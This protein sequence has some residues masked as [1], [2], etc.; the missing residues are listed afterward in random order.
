M[1][2]PVVVATSGPQPWAPTEP[3]APYTEPQAIPQGRNA[4]ESPVD[5]VHKP[6]MLDVFSGPNMPLSKAFQWC[7]WDTIAFDRKIQSTSAQ[8]FNH[9]LSKAPGQEALTTSSTKAD[10]IAAAFDC[11]TKSRIREIKRVIY[12]ASGK[13]RNLPTPLRSEQ[14][15]EGL[16]TLEGH[17]RQRVETDNAVTKFM[18]TLLQQHAEKGGGSMRENPNRSLHWWLEQEIQMMSTGAWEDTL[19]TACVLMAARA[20][21]QRL[22]HN[23][24]EISQ[25]PDM[26]CRHIHS[27]NEWSVEWRGELASHVEAE[28]TACL[29]FYVAVSVSWWAMRTGRATM[30]V[31]RLPTISSTGDR[32]GW[33]NMDPK[34]VRE[35]AMIPTALEVGVSIKDASP[36]VALP[37]LRKFLP[38]RCNA[39]DAGIRTSDGHPAQLSSDQVYVGQGHHSHRLPVTKWTCPF[40]AGQHGSHEECMLWY[41]QHVHTELESRL[42]ELYSKTLVCDCP[43]GQSCEAD[44]LISACFCKLARKKGK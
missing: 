31:H 26:T 29:V 14:Y 32:R 37:S 11:S 35:M 9:D 18:L 16:P 30:K 23:I 21:K 28:Y 12:T 27:G 19:Y 7:G 43:M 3:S 22:R 34:V 2:N 8:A 33:E 4:T 42:P 10:F 39:R 24:A 25:W 44:V 17:D 38:S 41:I 6:L 20:K 15:P 13:P 1:G 40:V 5:S 36:T